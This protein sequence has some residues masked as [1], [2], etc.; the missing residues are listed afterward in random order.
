MPGVTITTAVRSGPIGS[1]VRTS[2]QA[3]FV[4]LTDRG[5][6]DKSVLVDSLAAFEALYGGYASYSYMHPTVE[7][8][9]EEGGTQCW[10]ARVAGPSATTGTLTLTDGSNDTVTFTANGP[11]AWSSDIT[12]T[13]A[14]GS[15]ASSR[16][17][18]LL[19]GGVA[20]FVATDTTATDQIISKFASSAVASYYVTVT[21]E[22]GGLVDIYANPQSLAAGDDDRS[23][24]VSSSYVAGMTLF[25]DSYGSGAVACPDSEVQ[26]VYQGLIA[27][28]NSH[29][30]IALLHT[31]AASTSA[32][33]RT[34][35]IAIRVAESNTEHA[36]LYWPWTNTPTVLAGVSRLIPPDGYVA[37]VRARAHNSTGSH[38]PAA[39]LVSVSRWVT[40]LE[41]E[42]DAATGALLDGDNV[43]VLRLIEGGIRV[44][45]A[46][47]MSA[48]TTNFRY[49]TA[50]DTINGIVFDASKTLEDLVFSV[51]DGRG[52][53]FAAVQARLVAVLEPRRISGALYEAFDIV[54]RRVD[55]GYTVKCNA[56]LNPAAQIADGL[57]KAKVGVRVSSVGDK[58]EVDIVKSNLTTSVI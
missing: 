10:I 29:N 20:V 25:N 43:N 40:S 49:I 35:G 7:T 33:A 44:Y 41:T 6:T 58:I 15:I 19:V 18:T 48:D 12:V 52:N 53:I 47:S 56:K 17:I 38:Q 2:S 8:Y 39:G 13:T 27:H 32:S 22:G 9:F 46:R 16:T 23:N 37:A 3:F 50:Q 51:I 4:G 30:R 54:G 5:P 36:A 24:V 34:T 57:I 42:A 1:T 14:A 21:D 31:A 28:A 11:G 45:G 55:M 26:A